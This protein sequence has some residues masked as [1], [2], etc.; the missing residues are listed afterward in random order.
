MAAR[1]RG[2]DDDDDDEDDSD[3]DARSSLGSDTAS[4][5]SF[6][7]A[8]PS[9][10]PSVA[11]ARGRDADAA[12]VAASTLLPPPP[13]PPEGEQVPP[14]AD[15]TPAVPA[16]EGAYSTYVERRGAQ[17]ERKT[18][19]RLERM[20]MHGRAHSRRGA[21]RHGRYVCLPLCACARVRACADKTERGA[22]VRWSVCVVWQ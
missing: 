2:S 3:G 20:M 13:P 4:E 8:A 11:V 16:D 17:K 10:R 14:P 9:V 1:R 15:A 6:G 18:H 19:L 22:H 7:T 5:G 12:S 21:H